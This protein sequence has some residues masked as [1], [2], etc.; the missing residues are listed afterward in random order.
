MSE[1]SDTPCAGMT[2]VCAVI[3]VLVMRRV[4]LA[5][6]VWDL[7][8]LLPQPPSLI[9]VL[10]SAS[11]SAGRLPPVATGGSHQSP[12]PDSPMNNWGRP[13]VP[14][15]PRTMQGRKQ[16]EGGHDA[17]IKTEEKLHDVLKRGKEERKDCGPRSS[18]A[19]GFILDD[20][21]IEL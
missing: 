5:A 2:E 12:C 15:H 21:I 6:T 11:Q 20:R 3:P 7:F 10:S 14:A 16:M 17:S 13:S 4:S 9:S 19:F 8:H 18:R 1:H